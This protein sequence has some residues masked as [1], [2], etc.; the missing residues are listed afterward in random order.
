MFYKLTDQNSQTHNSCQW[1]EGVTHQ[2]DGSGELCGPGWLHC[3]THPLL[4]VLLN[5]LHANIYN[6][7]LW[8]VEC[9]G[10]R[11]NDKGLKVGFTVMTTVRQIPLPAITI[12][13]GVK[14]AILC[15]KKIYKDKEWNTWA[16]N[17]LSGKNRTHAAYAAA[18]AAYAAADAAAADAA[19]DAADAADAAYAAAAAAAYAAD[20]AADAAAADAAAADAAADAAAHAAAAAAYAADAAAAA[21]ADAAA[22]AA[23]DAAYAAAAAAAYAGLDLIALAEE[24]CSV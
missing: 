6:P 17:W 13:Q 14:F 20:A 22:H 10:Q 21:A 3:Y 7:V 8:E 11:K 23:A 18:D 5:S 15:V 1:G 19:A 24:A 12:E 4:A 16:D 2:T 9:S